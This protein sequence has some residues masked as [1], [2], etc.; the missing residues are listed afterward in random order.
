MKSNGKYRRAFTLAKRFTK[1]EHGAFTVVAIV[2]FATLVAVGGLAIDLGRLYG[3]HGQMQA[4]VDNIA[5]A[6]ATELN[7]TTTSITRSMRA[8]IGDDDG[9][10]GGNDGGPLVDGFQNF[11]EGNTELS[12]VRV[13]Y[14]SD[15]GNDLGPIVP[16][17]WP[18]DVVLCTPW[19][20]GAGGTACTAAQS[21][22]ARFVE[23]V[24][25]ERQVDYFILPIVDLFRGL[26]GA[27]PI[28]DSATVSL[29]ATA[30][31]K[32]NLCNNI[33]LMMCN[34]SQSANP[35]NMDFTPLPG[36]QFLAKSQGAPQISPGNFGPLA[37]WGNGA[38]VFAHGI[39]SVNPNTACV[40]E[41]VPSEPGAMQ[42]PIE[43]GMNT[44]MD[45]YPN[46]SQFDSYP[47]AANVTKGVTQQA[48]S[49][50]TNQRTSAAPDTMPFPRHDCFGSTGPGNIGSCAGGDPRVSLDAN[51][52]R[53]TYWQTN[54]GVPLPPALA[55]ATR[56]QVY[57]YEN[58]NGS[59]LDGA[60]SR[61]PI[62][63]PA[64]PP[65]IPDRRKLLVAIVN[66]LDAAG[67]PQLPSGRSNFPFIDI[68]EVF[69][70]EP[71]GNIEYEP[72]EDETTPFDI[73]IE[74]IGKASNGPGPSP[75]G[76]L[77]DFPV[78]YR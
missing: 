11:A 68:A 57:E 3:V 54:Y 16:T 48:P 75:N 7:G 9:V 8:I 32:R 45:F 70:T 53:A 23:V 18:G 40:E 15:L 43:D 19:D 41:E 30:G 67:N 56:H 76:V 31:F 17:P 49:C 27:P 36:Q 5:L 12:I 2:F 29:R 62:C 37:M 6:G 51:W 69:L 58:L 13:T 39:A 26:G 59:V 28:A 4:Y 22:D 60:E 33:P 78:L 46:G 47:P 24:A 64:P 42:G 71:V 21:Q 72:W 63:G 1:S 61:T 52:D 74:M 10:A 50:Q 35:A 77:H 44:R 66:C 38:N 25:T 65:N 14:L 34:P 20:G 73:W 55:N